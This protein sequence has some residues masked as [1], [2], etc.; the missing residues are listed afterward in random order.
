MSK[1][2]KEL[3]LF[4]T[5]PKPFLAESPR[6]GPMPVIVGNWWIGAGKN[7]NG[8]LIL[9]S[10]QRE[11]KD[12]FFCPDD[13]LWNEHLLGYSNTEGFVAIMKD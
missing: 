12:L 3:K 4:C 9:S 6:Y 8:F 7:A 11:L 13:G 2:K 1:S 5:V 10:G